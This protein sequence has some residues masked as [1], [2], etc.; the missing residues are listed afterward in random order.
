MKITDLEGSFR[1]ITDDKG[2]NELIEKIED[3]DGLLFQCPKCFIKLKG[4]VGCHYVM[5]WTPKVPQTIPPVPGRW[6]LV[7]TSLADV[8]LVA[9]SSS[10]HLVG[11]C[12]AHFF[13]K[14]GQIESLT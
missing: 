10:V 3:A 8:T 4:P 9:G 7:G 5:C 6:K 1:R 13:V 14:N 2:S 12:Q 11:G